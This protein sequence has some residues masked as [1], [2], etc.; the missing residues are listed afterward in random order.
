MMATILGNQLSLLPTLSFMLLLTPFP[1]RTLEID[2][3]RDLTY[4][5]VWG[6]ILGFVFV[7]VFRP[8]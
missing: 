1:T 8:G 2:M 3:A 7:F 5:F 4:V 6:F